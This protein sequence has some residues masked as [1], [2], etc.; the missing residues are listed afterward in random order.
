MIVPWGVV[1]N[2]YILGDQRTRLISGRRED[3]IIG[4]GTLHR[5]LILSNSVYQISLNDVGSNI[6]VKSTV[7]L[8]CYGLVVSRWYAETKRKSKKCMIR[9]MSLSVGEISMHPTKSDSVGANTKSSVW[10]ETC[11]GIITKFLILLVFNKPKIPQCM[12]L[13]LGYPANS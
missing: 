12:A 9:Y 13:R 7:I 5:S 8:E 1:L 2:Y 10:P 6:Y 4:I 11:V 3:L